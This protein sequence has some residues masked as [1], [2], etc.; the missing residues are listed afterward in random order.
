MLS[1]LQHAWDQHFERSQAMPVRCGSHVRTMETLLAHQ[2]PL[3]GQMTG[4]WRSQALPFGALRA[5]LPG[6]SAEQQV[7]VG[8][9]PAYLSW[10]RVE[11]S[12]LENVRDG[13]LAPGNLA[14]GEVLF[15]LYDELR[16]PRSHL[17]VLEAISNGR[18]A[19]LLL[20][21][22]LMRD[23]YP[24]TLL[25]AGRRPRYISALEQAHHH[26]YSALVNVIGSAVE[27]GL[28]MFLEACAAVPDELQRTLREVAD[29]CEIDADYLG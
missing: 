24:A 27:A 21:L 6:W 19:R 16:E 2:S 18:T 22:Q 9:V 5:F 25:L 28:N 14:L 10:F 13:M 20:N 23:G 12:L 11:R 15:L 7:V 8:G 4:Q 29:V 1:A 17:A 3:F 26:Q